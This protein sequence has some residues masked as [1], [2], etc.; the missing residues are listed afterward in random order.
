MKNKLGQFIS[1]NSGRPKGSKNKNRNKKSGQ[2]IFEKYKCFDNRNIVYIVN[3]KGTDFYKI[4]RSRK[5]FGRLNEFNCGCPL[6]L[7]V[8]H[9][10]EFDTWADA[11]KTEK[12]LHKIFKYRNHKLEWFKLNDECISLIKDIKSYDDVVI[13]EYKLYGRLPL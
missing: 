3:A 12:K 6:K 4:G 8:I 9:L 10:M 13:V 5:L 1:G 11:M 7:S 2:F